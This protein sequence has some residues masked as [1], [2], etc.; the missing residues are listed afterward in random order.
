MCLSLSYGWIFTNISWIWCIFT[1]YMK[2]CACSI[3][4][5]CD[6]TLSRLHVI[7]RTRCAMPPKLINMS[8]HWI[9]WHGTLTGTSLQSESHWNQLI[10]TVM[11]SLNYFTLDSVFQTFAACPES[12]WIKRAAFE[13]L[14]TNGH[15]I[16]RENLAPA[17]LLAAALY[18]KKKLFMLTQ[19][20][21]VKKLTSTTSHVWKRNCPESC[22]RTRADG[23]IIEVRNYGVYESTSR[24]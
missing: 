20:M 15:I 9:Y 21:T 6:S 23:A 22:E 3:K 2:Y 5:L 1:C 18:V 7:S 19:L 8:I 16:L 17:G 13:L 14:I 12:H 11:L 10:S 4:Y 24:I